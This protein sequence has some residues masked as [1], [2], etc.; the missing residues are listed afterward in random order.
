MVTAVCK[1]LL[2]FLA[3]TLVFVFVSHDDETPVRGE[4]TRYRHAAI[5]FAAEH[6]DRLDA[7]AQYLDALSPRPNTVRL[8]RGMISGNDLLVDDEWSK[9]ETL[10]QMLEATPIETARRERV[11]WRFGLEYSSG[12]LDICHYYDLVYNAPVGGGDWT[13]LGEGFISQGR[14]WVEY[15]QN[16]GDGLYYDYEFCW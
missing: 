15:V 8:D 16:L 2:I 11:G 3:V 9:D 10:L 1:N 12:M 5:S 13:P 4:K 7:L 14:D 6:R